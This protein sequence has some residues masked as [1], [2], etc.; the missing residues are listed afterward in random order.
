MRFTSRQTNSNANEGTPFY[1]NPQGAQQG[2]QPPFHRNEYVAPAIHSS[3]GNL[4][5]SAKPVKRQRK[6]KLCVYLLL[7]AF[8]ILSITSCI[9]IYLKFMVPRVT[10]STLNQAER[11]VLTVNAYWKK[12]MEVTLRGQSVNY[13]T[14]MDALLVKTQPELTGKIPVADNLVFD[15]K[16]TQAVVRQWRV[17]VGS[18][19]AFTWSTKN[20]DVLVFNTKKAYETWQKTRERNTKAMSLVSSD[21]SG[22]FNKTFTAASNVYIV[23]A[24]NDKADS[25]S[26]AIEMNL[27]LTTFNQT[28][29]TKDIL[30]R[31]SLRTNTDNTRCL[32]NLSEPINMYLLMMAAN[33]SALD[34]VEYTPNITVVTQETPRSLS[35]LPTVGMIFAAIVFFAVIAP[36]IAIVR[37]LANCFGWCF[38]S[39]KGKYQPLPTK[40]PPAQP[41]T[42]TAEN[43]KLFVYADE[44]NLE[45]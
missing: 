3:K 7:W 2:N 42:T 14:A 9:Y 8:T 1:M 37:L 41:E 5:E 45:I 32:F 31:C 11:R 30:G 17:G 28:F 4:V 29:A 15:L 35:E 33:D 18:E 39:K 25:G 22:T 20:C 13:V 26:G 23:I 44:T 21:N 16:G 24:L 38:R 36:L 10:T 40:A 19:I 34:A 12:R 27:K 43:K 6:L